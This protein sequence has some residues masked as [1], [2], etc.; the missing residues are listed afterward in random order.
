MFLDRW[1]TILPL[2]GILTGCLASGS[3]ASV[4]PDAGASMLDAGVRTDS[5][6]ANVDFRSRAPKLK[7]K[8]GEQLTQDLAQALELSRDA[9]CRELGRYDCAQEAHRIV[10]G[11]VEPYRLRIDEPLPGIGVSAP[12]AVDRLALAA[13]GARE[14]ADFDGPETAVVFGPLVSG[15]ADARALVVDEIYERLLGRAP[16]REERKTLA[17]WTEDGLSDRDF[18]TLACFVV[19]TSLEHLFY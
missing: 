19:A 13:C 18:A 17:E 11:G 7:R 5:G 16:D 8:T 4:D 12:I 6:T 14:K 9:V 2:A 15:Q 1:T 3:D 10:L